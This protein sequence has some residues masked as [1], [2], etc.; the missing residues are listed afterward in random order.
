VE[1]GKRDYRDAGRWMRETDPA[2]AASYARDYGDRTLYG[3]GRMFAETCPDYFAD[4]IAEL[5]A[6]RG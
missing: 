6:E 3:L 2:S 5:R 4:I 1:Y